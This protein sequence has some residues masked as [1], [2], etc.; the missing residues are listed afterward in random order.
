MEKDILYQIVKLK[1]SVLSFKEILLFVGPISPSLLKRRLNYYVQK[2]QLYAVR[3]GFYVKDKHY[4]RYELATKIF[5]PAYISFETV[6]VKAGVIFQYY[7][8]IFVATYQTKTIV[9]DG[10]EYSYKKL[11]DT[12]LVDTTGVENKGTYFIASPERAFLDVLYLNKNYYF[13]NLSSL[14]F[15]K[16]LAI[17]PIYHN[18]RM[19]KVVQEQ[20]KAFKEEWALKKEDHKHTCCMPD[21]G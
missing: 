19:E 13:D 5:T 1:S 12:L 15:D 11:K 17:L 3:K 16:V 20:F 6:L 9:C 8:T 14:D 2:K 7:S 10:Q 21:V 4:D 18:K